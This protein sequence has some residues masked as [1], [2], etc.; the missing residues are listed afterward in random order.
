MNLFCKHNYVKQDDLIFCTKC[1]KQKKVEC[2]HIWETIK[3]YE[4]TTYRIGKV[5]DKNIVLKQT[6]K[7][8]GNIRSIEA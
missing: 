8:C 3:Q 4:A 6:C 2:N 7:H 1:G 5:Q